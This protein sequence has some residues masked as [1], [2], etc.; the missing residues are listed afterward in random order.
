MLLDRAQMRQQSRGECVT[1]GEPEKARKPAE[2]FGVG[3]KRVRLL[4]GQHLQAML[5]PAQEFIS[6]RQGVARRGIDPA[7]GGERG[8]RGDRLAAAQVGISP[9]GDEL[10]GLHEKL[11]LAD[12]AA[13][14]LDVVAFDGD[15]AMAAVGVDLL[16]HGV[17]IGD[18]GVIEEFAPD[19]WRQVA[20]K[21]FAGGDIAGAGPRLDQRRALP[22]L[23]TAFV[24]IERGFRGDR[25]LR[26]G[27]VGAK[28]QI[29]AKDIAVGRALL[30]KLHQIARQPHEKRRRLDVGRQRRRGV[31]EKHHEVD[32]AGEVQ[33][34]AAHFA[35]RQHDVAGTR[36]G[37][38]RIART[39]F[40]AHN[41][42]AEQ[43]ADGKA[44][45]RLG[46][47]G[48]RRRH[49]RDRP[50]AADIGER[51]QER[52]VRFHAAQD[53]HQDSRAARWRSGFARVVDKRRKLLLRIAA[54]EGKRARRIGLEEFPEV[55]RR[56]GNRTEDVGERRMLSDQSRERAT[57][58]AA[59]DSGEP[60]AQTRAPLR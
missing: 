53:A 16:L 19:E 34:I 32:V 60:L 11:D 25:D 58:G 36:F 12:A 28:P 26:G 10:L 54:K 17:N 44:E 7:A 55:G 15:F 43:V 8:K 35:H 13:A 27:R 39:E 37:V 48:Q 14:E 6:R 29:D 22:V 56:F 4:V 51:D 23:A 30:Q 42:L 5:D 59:R 49:A 45:R 21:L 1:V 38:L 18:R 20:Q 31:I 47:F 33:L 52:R 57:R 9:A 40:F 3:G 50:N 24:I 2:R 41:R 46:D